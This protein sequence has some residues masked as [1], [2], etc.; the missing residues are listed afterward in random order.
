MSIVINADLLDDGEGKPATQP[1]LPD[2]VYP[3]A[4]W[5][6]WKQARTLPDGRTELFTVNGRVYTAPSRV[7]PG[8]VFRYMRAMRKRTGEEEALADL[9]YDTLGDGVM[10]ALATEKL[11]VE[12]FQQVMKVVQKHTAGAARVTLGN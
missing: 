11:S 5:Q 2:G 6:Q 8:A 9:M 7:D 12:E 3:E 10:D 4:D 1:Q